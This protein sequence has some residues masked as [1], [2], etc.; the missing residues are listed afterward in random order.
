MDGRLTGVHFLK[1]VTEVK[2]NTGDILYREGDPNDCAYVIETGEILLYNEVNGERVEC[3]RRGAGSI[4]G[5][6]SVLTGQPRA[7]TVEAISP[8]IAY[9]ISAEDI[10]T[11]LEALDP[12]L[13]ACFDTTVDFVTRFF[14]QDKEEQ[15]P[16][17]PSTLH[18]AHKLIEKFRFELDIEKGLD[19]GEFSLVFQPII[20]LANNRMVGFEALMRWCHP[21]L[22]NIPPDRFILVAEEMGSIGRLTD[23]ALQ[24]AC[25]VLQHIRTKSSHESDLFASVN[26]SGVDMARDNFSESL[27]QVL[28]KN[29]LDPKNLKLELTETALL[30]NVKNTTENFE[31]IRHLGCGISIDDFGTGYSNLVYLKSLPLTAIKIDRAFTNDVRTNPFSRG[32]IK[33][34]VGLGSDLN[35][36]IVAEGLESKEDV[37]V[38]HDLGCRFAQGYYF[39]APVSE[40]EI[41]KKSMLGI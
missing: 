14:G 25:M 6:T 32:I 24:Q 38:V 21:R 36:D 30:P 39:S 23:Y 20:E 29:D 18:N 4:L 40:S 10:L 1:S 17:A 31:Q 5:E 28:D 12:I 3:E 37:K 8:C 9:R 22:G 13:R 7:V 19:Q 2:L 27:K 35:V 41:I 16:F 34:L 15:T 33:M 26:I 11:R